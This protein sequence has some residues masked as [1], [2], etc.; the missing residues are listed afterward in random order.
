[1]PAEQ[2]DH[3]RRADT[4]VVSETR[5]GDIRTQGLA[6]TLIAPLN[7]SVW[8]LVRRLGSP[9][10][11]PDVATAVGLDT[12]KAKLILDSLTD[13][14]LLERLPLRANRRQP[15]YRATAESI[16]VSY[17]PSSPDDCAAGAGRRHRARARREPARHRTAARDLREH[18]RLDLQ[19]RLRQAR[20]AQPRGTR[21]PAGC[22]VAHVRQGTEDRRRH[23][24]RPAH[25]YPVDP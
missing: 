7:L 14:G 10:S 1:L 24:S 9:A 19:A 18:G 22:A 3:F 13:A 12:A 8:T 6:D 21:E 17:D 11:L 4:G 5:I 23:G 20:R 2:P 15:T 16:V 25:R